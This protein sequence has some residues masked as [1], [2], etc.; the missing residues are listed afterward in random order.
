[1]SKMWEAVIVVRVA[2]GGQ[3]WNGSSY[4]NNTM[5]Q[6]VVIVV[7]DANGY[8]NTKALLEGSYGVGSVQ[9]LSE[10]SM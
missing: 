8:F 7:P 5:G 2:G 9:R 6:T 4:K 3:S 10:K 1:M